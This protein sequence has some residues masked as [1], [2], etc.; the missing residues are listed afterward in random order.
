MRSNIGTIEL[1]Y[2]VDGEP[3][4]PWLVFSNSLA[5]DMTMWDEQVFHLKTHYQILRYDQRGHGLSDAPQGQ[6]SIDMF[7]EDLVAL[8]DSLSIR[9]AS[10]VGISMGGMTVLTL[11]KNHPDRVDKLVVCDCGPASSPA[12]AQQWM[13]R[14]A[15]VSAKGM[16]SIVDETIGRWFTKEILEND[17]PVVDLVSKMITNTPVSG[18]IGS[19]HALATFDL[20]PGLAD[21]AAPT[22][23]IAGEHDAVVGGT[24]ILSKTV[25]HSQ[26]TTIPRAG[27][28]CNLENPTDFLSTLTEFL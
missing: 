3:N 6:Y 25:P 1:N 15:K 8:L 28:L 18:F 12:A 26:F 4:L 13:D 22:L 24:Q 19:A 21:L 16:G 9:K 2:Q 10:F 7:A 14:I 20:R 11:A 23:F 27:H 5:T 17:R